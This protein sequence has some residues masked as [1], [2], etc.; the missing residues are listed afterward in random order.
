MAQIPLI[1]NFEGDFVLQLIAI[2]SD[3]TIDELA[4][5]AAHHSVGRR[6]R[7]R[8]GQVIRVRKA[9]STELLR[10]DQRVSEVGLAPM[11]SLE[12]IWEPRKH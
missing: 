8:P 12:F 1:S 6:V 10:R 7:N 9:G 2:D 3:N 4:A 5:A 11:D